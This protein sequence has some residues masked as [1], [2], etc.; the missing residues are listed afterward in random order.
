MEKMS[1]NMCGKSC[2]FNCMRWRHV[3]TFWFPCL[4][5]L[6]SLDQGTNAFRLSPVTVENI[7]KFDLPSSPQ[8]KVENPWKCLAARLLHWATIL[9]YRIIKI[10][11]KIYV[12]QCDVPYFHDLPIFP[13]CFLVYLMGCFMFIIQGTSCDPSA[14]AIPHASEDLQHKR[15]GRRP[16]RLGL[17]LDVPSQ[18]VRY[19]FVEPPIFSLSQNSQQRSHQGHFLKFEV[20]LQNWQKNML[21][22]F[23]DTLD[24]G[25]IKF[26]GG[27]RSNDTLW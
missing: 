27:F 6:Q 16:E 12:K 13:T 10:I 3:A 15:H 17:G 18:W 24:S 2:F 20:G 11:H 7:A 4:Q 25:C 23:L 22:I 8:P 5:S 26:G 1:G 9:S 14:L 19:D 21:I